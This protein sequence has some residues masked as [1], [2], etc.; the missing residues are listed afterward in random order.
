MIV[1]EL[2]ILD[3]HRKSFVVV[4]TIVEKLTLEFG[5]EFVYFTEHSSSV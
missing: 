5:C 2:Q 1:F 3:L 4:R